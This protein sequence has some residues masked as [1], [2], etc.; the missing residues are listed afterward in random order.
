[1]SELFTAVL[2]GAEGFTRLY[3]IKRLKPDF[4]QHKGAVDQFIDEAKLGSQLLHG[5]IVPVLDFGRIGTGYFLAQEY[6]R[7]RNLA[8]LCERHGERIGEPLPMSLVCYIAHEALGALAYAHERTD[9]NGHPLSIVHRDVSSG[10][11]MVTEQGEVKLLDFGIVRA[12]DRVSRTD[13]GQVKGNAV[14]MAPEQA[15][16]QPVDNRADLFSLG[17]VMYFA[18]SGRLLYDSHNSAEAFYQATTGL[19]ADHLARIR[20][21][22]PQMAEILER[23]LAMDANNR[24]PNAR[25]FAEVLAP[26]ISGCKGQLA[27]LMKALFGEDLRRQTA[28]FR[29]KLPEAQPG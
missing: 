23:A 10:N 2:A 27:T 18:L 8:E 11:I 9:D 1:M 21:L 19:T 14:F 22:P 29:A 17:M 13:L 26:F 24:Y 28:S 12:T 6:V 15:R 20:A 25:E 7:G 4:A 16:G 3:V 5:N